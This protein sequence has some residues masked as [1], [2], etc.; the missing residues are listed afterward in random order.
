[1]RQVSE[2]IVLLRMIANSADTVPDIDP[3][4][5][6]KLAEYLLQ[7]KSDDEEHRQLLSHVPRLARWNALRLGL[8]DQLADESS[9]DAQ[10][11]D[12]LRAVLG[13]EVDL[14]SED[15]R[16]R[17]RRQLLQMVSATL[18]D[19][20]GTDDKRWKVFD[21]GNQAMLAFYTVQA[22]LLRVPAET[23]AAAQ[24]PSAILLA[25]ITYRAGQLDKSKLGADEQRLLGTL[26]SELL[27]ADFL[28]VNDLQYTVMLQRIWLQTLSAY[29]TQQLP[30][31]T[32]GRA[33]HCGG[34]TGQRSGARPRVRS[35]A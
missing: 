24:S 12:V 1:M 16:Q 22:K 28:A 23:Y 31:K 20:V 33:G 15:D 14:S 10:R 29:L 4:S 8:A 7:F 32:A 6:Q 35:D 21:Q 3:L 17:V 9:R 13:E 19:V 26:P 27:T 11:Q 5:G 25:M 30:E 2:R 18:T 34:N